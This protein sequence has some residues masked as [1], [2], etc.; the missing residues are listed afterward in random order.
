MHNIQSQEKEKQFKINFHFDL[1]F[2]LVR[3]EPEKKNTI[4][5]PVNLK[6]ERFGESVIFNTKKDTETLVK[7]RD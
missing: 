3:T 1:I 2:E 4:G 7:W 6:F 5:Q